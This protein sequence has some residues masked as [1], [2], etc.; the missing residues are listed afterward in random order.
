MEWEAVFGLVNMLALACWAV[1]IVMPRAGR[2]AYLGVAPRWVVPL[3]FSA[4]YTMLVMIYFAETG[5]GYDS[6]AAVRRLFA[7]DPMLLAGWL[8]FLAFDLLVGCLIADRMDR[9]GVHRVVQAGPLLAVF[10]FGPA[11]LLFGLA[12]ELAYRAQ[13]ARRTGGEG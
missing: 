2:W 11:G 1:L 8:H 12:V 7:S 13:N 4:L 3:V 10:L 9:A 5:G 6:V